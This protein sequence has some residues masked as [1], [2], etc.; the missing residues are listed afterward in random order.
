M[1]SHGDEPP[2]DD[3]A[4]VTAASD[5]IGEM[6]IE[7]E[8]E[9]V[10]LKHGGYKKRRIGVTHPRHLPTKTNVAAETPYLIDG[11]KRGHSTII[12]GVGPPKNL[13]AHQP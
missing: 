13:H 12:S 4:E 6:V 5:A 7:G 9:K 2:G 11:N 1:D 3:D 8:F 10:E